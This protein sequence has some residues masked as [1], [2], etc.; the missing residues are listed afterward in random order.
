MGTCL[1]TGGAG[2]IGSHLADRLVHEGHTVTVLDD[3]SNGSESNLRAVRDDVR[4]IVGRVEDPAAMA[5]AARGQDIVFHLAALGS[6][7]R[8]V[9]APQP[10]HEANA[11]GTLG[12]LQ[13][14]RD[15]GVGRF[16]F[17]SSS[18][19]YG[20][21]AALPKTE[22]EVGNVLSPYALSKKVGEEYVRLFSELYGMSAVALRFFN[23]FGPRQRA[24]HVYAAVIPRFLDAALHGKALT[25]HGD[26]Q[27]SR[28]FTFVDNNVEGLI[29]TSQAAAQEVDGRVFNLACEGRV[30]LLEIIDMI[31]E[32]LG[33][34]L[35]I[36]HI[37]PRGGDIR[38]SFAD[39]TALRMAAGY[40]P[41]VELAQGLERTR[42]W[43]LAGC[44]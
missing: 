6:V 31:Q 20:D 27:Q 30:T 34:E 13:A 36:D 21:H 39:T 18:S 37:D 7:P 44:P 24:D 32:M 8:S 35:E 28:D 38:H 2:F 11:T 40:Q 26:G 14:A 1:I 10:T 25:V 41:V 29:L 3:L 16:V 43:F 12:A 22:S 33:R 42:D 5:E 15:A 19:V 23:V 17:A 9:A 4:L